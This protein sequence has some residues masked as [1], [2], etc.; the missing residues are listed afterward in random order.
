MALG[1]TSGWSSLADSCE[2]SDIME[3]YGDGKMPMQM[4]MFGEQ[5]YGRGPSGQG[6]AGMM[7]MMMM[8]EG[9]GVSSAL[10]GMSSLGRR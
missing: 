8:S 3:H 9:G 6:G 7:Q 1:M 10:L 4:R 2:K 5:V